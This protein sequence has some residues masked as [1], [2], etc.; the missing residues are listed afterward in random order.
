MGFQLLLKRPFCKYHARGI[1]Q[2][3]ASKHCLYKS[4]FTIKC[5]KISS[6]AKTVGGRCLMAPEKLG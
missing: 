2:N 3:T 5:Q 4:P 1:A 6:T